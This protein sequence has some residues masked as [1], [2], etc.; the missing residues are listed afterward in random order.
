MAVPSEPSVSATGQLAR[1][2][3]GEG[4]PRAAA[5][6]SAIAGRWDEL[7]ERARMT[8]KALLGAALG[9]STPHV[10]T[11]T[12][13]LT[14]ALDEPNDFHAKAIEQAKPELLAMLSSWFDGV[15]DLRIQREDSQAGA[16]RPARMT[17]EMV[18]SQR[19]A[20]L[21]KKSPALDAA[22]EVL[23]LDLAD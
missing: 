9:S 13:E 19:L 21:R 7:V 6:I 2:V 12:G 18:K 23:D 3:V 16:E 15:T 10:I 17:D 20:A 14:I 22:V 11:K 4:R 8:G 5:D 1:E